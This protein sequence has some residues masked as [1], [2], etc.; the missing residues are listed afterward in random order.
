MTIDQAR[1]LFAEAVRELAGAGLLPPDLAGF[2]ITP[3]L[4]MADLPIDSAGRMAL[5]SDIETRG[6]L[7]LPLE[8][9]G[10]VDTVDDFAAL[11]LRASQA[12]S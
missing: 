1:A 8:E 2:T 6:H 10:D 7:V 4:R 11:V 5:V 12:E 9:I 3:G